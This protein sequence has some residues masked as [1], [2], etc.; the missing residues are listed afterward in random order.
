[1]IVS[2]FYLF[3]A[4]SS[5]GQQPSLKSSQFSTPV[6]DSAELV[7]MTGDIL[8]GEGP[9]WH[10]DG[11]LLFTD[12]L[13]DLIYKMDPKTGIKEVYLSPSGAANGL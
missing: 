7:H 10:P 6:P 12:M 13:A 11:Y 8:F 3:L 5:F 9:L 4:G 1:M 2:A